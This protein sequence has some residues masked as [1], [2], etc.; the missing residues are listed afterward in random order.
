M[1][2]KENY[3]NMAREWILSAGTDAEK[4]LRACRCA[5]ELGIGVAAS[6]TGV[7]R[8]TISRWL[9]VFQGFEGGGVAEALEALKNKSRIGQK[10]KNKTPQETIDRIVECREKTGLGARLIKFILELKESE[11]TINKI[12]KAKGYMEKP[13]PKPRVRTD[14]SAYRA[15]IAPFRIIQIDIKYLCDIPF[16]V[17]NLREYKLPQYQITARDYKSGTTFIGFAHNKD[18]TSVAI[19][20]AYVI[21]QLKSAGIDVSNIIFLSDNGSEFKHILKKNGFSLYE[22]ILKSRG[23]NY[24]FIPVASPTYNSDVESFHNRIEQE[25]YKIDEIYSESSMFYKTWFYMVWYN[26]IRPNRNKEN[27]SPATILKEYGFSNIEKITT[28]HPIFV[29]KFVKNIELIKGNGTLR[30]SPVIN[31]NNNI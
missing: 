13:K 14:M 22:E 4:R 29:D 31:F 8:K 1:R 10:H 24:R 19:F 7:D 26:T 18:S 20:T 15:T 6:I 11:K 12:L 5:K 9:Q 25:L 17:C 21:E 30:W 3:H 16:L 2:T 28:I 23:V 27:K